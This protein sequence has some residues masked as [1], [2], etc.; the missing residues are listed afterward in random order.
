LFSF[1]EVKLSSEERK[2][3]DAQE[4][5]KTKGPYGERSALLTND[6]NFVPGD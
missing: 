2:G 1:V 4:L 6:L 3:R 5:E